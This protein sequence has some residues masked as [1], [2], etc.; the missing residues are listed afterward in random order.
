MTHYLR[1]R[2]SLEPFNLNIL[3]F[4]IYILYVEK[5]KTFDVSWRFFKATNSMDWAA[6]HLEALKRACLEEIKANQPLKLNGTEGVTI[7]VNGTAYE[8]VSENNVTVP[9]TEEF[10]LEY[11]EEVEAVSCEND[12]RGHGTCRNGN[13]YSLRRLLMQNVF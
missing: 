11:L 9:V 10:S 1:H 5:L 8:N 12:C 4:V 7:W 2:E 3:P 6:Q 13:Y